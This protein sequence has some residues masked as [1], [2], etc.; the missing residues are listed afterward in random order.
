MQTS[1]EN[2]TTKVNVKFG[3]AN[4]VNYGQLE[5]RELGTRKAIYLQ[6]FSLY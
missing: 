6:Y 4:I 1:Q 2:F 5:N 3:G